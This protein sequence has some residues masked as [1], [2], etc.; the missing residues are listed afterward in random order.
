MRNRG[1]DLEWRMEINLL[2]EAE[3]PTRVY[4]RGEMEGIRKTNA[5]M[6]SML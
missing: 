4:R 3:E 6:Q 2:V 5:T 1:D